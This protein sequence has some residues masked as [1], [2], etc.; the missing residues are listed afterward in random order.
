MAVFSAVISCTDQTLSNQQT[1]RLPY[2]SL[3][4]SWS[5]GNR[6]P[7]PGSTRT[8]KGAMRSYLLC[9]TIA[10]PHSTM[11]NSSLWFCIQLLFRTRCYFDNYYYMIRTT[12]FSTKVEC[13]CTHFKLFN[14]YWSTRQ[15]RWLDIYTNKFSVI[16]CYALCELYFID[17][18]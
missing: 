6:C 14:F 4:R 13:N 8:R 5:T 1:R 10:I 17:A 3:R 16:C 11:L 12:T 2:G 7:P 18:N 15:A 9:N